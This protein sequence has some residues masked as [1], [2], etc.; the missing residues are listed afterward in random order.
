MGGVGVMGVK[1]KKGLCDG[2]SLSEVRRWE[3]NVR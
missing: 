1:G 3:G 2:V